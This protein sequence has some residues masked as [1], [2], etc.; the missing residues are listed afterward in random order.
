[1]PS[2]SEAYSQR[3]GES[4]GLDPR[5]VIVGAAVSIVG[6]GA[7]LLALLVA[8]TP[9]GEAFGAGDP[10]A[11][12]RLGGILAG[13]GAPTVLLGV[14][15]VLPSKRRQQLGVLVGAAISVA[16]VW[17]FSRAYPSRWVLAD[18]PLVFETAVVYVT[19]G[20]VAL[21]FVFVALANFRRANDPHGPVT[22]EIEKGGE[23]HRVEVT[24]EELRE[25]R[26][27]ANDGG[28]EIVTEIERQGRQ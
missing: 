22:L 2:L 10:Y 15:A 21:W 23:T 28:E 6:A 26:A 25:Y 17:L 11:A 13:L 20:F 1:M 27:M 12:K 14:V 16:G 9:L 19:G 5:R 24:P 4:A 7:M 8:T 3:R 18:D